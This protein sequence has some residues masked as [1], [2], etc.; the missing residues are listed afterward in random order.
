MANL[1]I[2][3]SQIGFL[4]ASELSAPSLDTDYSSGYVARN[5][6]GG[7]RPETVRI[8]SAATSSTWS[9]DHGSAVQ[10]E[11]LFIARADLIRRGDS[12]A[13]TWT[14]DGSA[15]NTFGTVDT[16]TG[17][18][19]VADLKG[20]RSEDLITT[21]TYSTAFQYWRFK[22]TTTAS[23]KHEYSKMFLGSWLDLVRD[24]IYPARFTREATVPMPR[25]VPWS[26]S[27]EWRGVTDATVQTLSD[28]VL[29]YR[30]VNPV[31]LYDPLDLVLPNTIR[32]IHAFI[33]DAVVTPEWPGTNRVQMSFL[34]A[35]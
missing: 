12:A 26:F 20:P 4:S 2:G 16:K 22:V 15:S 9:W 7:G 33:T 31:I 24:P 23:F 21:F 13:S 14:V 19:N 10:P 28:R 30:D 18:F 17:T 25:A 27:L 5:L 6:Y 3:Y 11:Y 34:E 35:I 1:L 29:K 32:V 8:A